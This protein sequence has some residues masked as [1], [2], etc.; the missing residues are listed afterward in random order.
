M[1][2]LL[3]KTL[4]VQFE[5][6][7][8]G[9]QGNIAFADDAGP[10]MTFQAVRS[11]LSDPD[12]GILRIWNLPRE[13]ATKFAEAAADMRRE[14]DNIQQDGLLT[15]EQRTRRIQTQ[16]RAYQVSVYAGLGDNVELMFVG[17]PVR[18]RPFVRDGLDYYT[19]IEIGDSFVV[20]EELAAA[21][22]YGV[23]EN[24][25]GLLELAQ[26][27]SNIQNQDDI[28]AVLSAVTINAASANVG[29]NSMVVGRTIDHINGITELLDLRWWVKDGEFKLVRRNQVLQDFAVV[30]DEEVNLMSLSEAEE[31]GYRE[32]ETVALPS[33]HPGRG[34]QFRMIGGRRVNT[35]VAHTEMTLETHG[36]AW[37]IRGRAF[38]AEFAN[39]RLVEN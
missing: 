14:I 22:I 23:L 5:G 16:L 8:L 39:V 27:V 38:P 21:P 2:S 30:L 32:F 6:N 26:K 36:N 13:F 35:R 29:G 1:A 25:A 34:V 17:D 15:D 20:L 28:E 31:N 4:R 37:T 24:S 9:F 3:G 11:V 7:G 12:R 19:E 18:V 10:R 33:I